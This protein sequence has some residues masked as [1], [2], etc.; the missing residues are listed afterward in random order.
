MITTAHIKELQA[1]AGTAGDLPLARI[2]DA[3][4][5]QTLDDMEE[6]LCRVLY[7]EE[8]TAIDSMNREA[9]IAE[10]ERVIAEAAAQ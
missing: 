6:L 9:A 5:G 4:L 2:C 8:A 10:C 1:E 3:A 7:P